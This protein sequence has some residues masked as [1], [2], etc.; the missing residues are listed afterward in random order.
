[1]K[2][3]ILL[4]TL[5][6]PLH[7]AAQSDTTQITLPYKDGKVVYEQISEVPG[8]SKT[9]IYGAAKKWLADIFK[10][11]NAVIKSENESTGQII[12][13]GSTTVTHFRK[14][15][16]LGMILDLKFSVQIDCKDDK[17]RIRIYNL[18]NERK[19]SLYNI[20][21][22][23]TIESID[24]GYRKKKNHDKWISTVTAI[25]DE[26]NAIMQSSKASILKS[27]SDIF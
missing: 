8:L 18:I 19:Y 10:N 11:S 27:K 22:S 2:K 20:D 26:F 9:E 17:Y 24:V 25:N 1:M 4:L 12:G 15:S 23:T 13:K 3:I 6:F 5:W 21:A 16:M 14:G 7:A